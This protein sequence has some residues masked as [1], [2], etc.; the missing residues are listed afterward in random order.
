MCHSR[1]RV[2]GVVNERLSELTL[3]PFTQTMLYDVFTWDA[4]GYRTIFLGWLAFSVNAVEPSFREPDFSKVPP[5]AN[6][7]T[8]IAAIIA[9]ATLDTVFTPP[10]SSCWSALLRDRADRTSSARY[11]SVRFR[12]T[13]CAARSTRKSDVRCRFDPTIGIP[14]PS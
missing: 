5:R 14:T 8:V 4:S 7:E 9:A 6:P 3:A 13:G 10:S 12:G 2:N 1:L 11:A